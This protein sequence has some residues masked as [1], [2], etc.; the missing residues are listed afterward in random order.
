MDNSNR[1]ILFIV[2][3]FVVL[4]LLVICVGGALLLMSHTNLVSVAQG[5]VASLEKATPL[6]TIAPTPTTMPAAPSVTGAED[7]VAQE[8]MRI[9]R[10]V[11]PSVVY[12]AVDKGSG[13]GFVWDKEGHIVTN[14]HVVAGTE[15]IQVTFSNDVSVAAKLVGQDPD[16][17]LAVIKVDPQGLDLQPVKLGDSLHAKPGERT[18]AIGNP[19]GLTGTMTVGIISA[20]GRSIDAPSGYLIPEAIQTD[21]AINPGNSGGPLLDFQG[22]VIGVNSQIR[23]AV[24][25]N[26]GIGFAIPVHIVKRVVPALIKQGHFYHPFIGMRGY[27]L[28]PE[29]NKLLD[30]PADQ[31]G[32]YVLATIP[33]YPAAK[34]GLKAGSVDTGKVIGLDENGKP[35]YLM[36]GG[37]IIVGIENQPVKKFDDIL[38]YL[39]RYA[40][41]GDTIHL[42]VLRNG[43]EIVI[44]VTLTTR[45]R[46][47]Q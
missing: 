35:I 46:S 9:Y 27:T 20:I 12:I 31:R 29:I 10:E 3:A 40:S 18:I 15:K 22:R 4:V 16:S 5:P 43:K 37:D 14:N 47:Q 1:N 24:R 26:S 21:A 44:P 45:P 23:S 34:A 33:D 25:S 19:F 8:Y 11:N 42:H 6:P 38:V 41:P 28:S 36:A 17:D 2:G 32:A 30:L 7:P 39:F 13:S